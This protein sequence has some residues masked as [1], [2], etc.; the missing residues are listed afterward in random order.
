[1]EEGET[2][3]VDPT[4][5]RPADQLPFNHGAPVRSSATESAAVHRAKGS[6]GE[7]LRSTPWV[8]SCG[9]A[10]VLVRGLALFRPI[11]TWQAVVRSVASYNESPIW[12][13]GVNA[14]RSVVH[15]NILRVPIVEHRP[16]F[17][18]YTPQEGIA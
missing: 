15:K 2:A 18:E 14:A 12:T 16:S 1:M 6:E 5:A 17:H 3:L 11:R 8:I 10:Y 13:S 4:A 9:G 7:T